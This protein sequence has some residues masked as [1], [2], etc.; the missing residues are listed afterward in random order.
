MNEKIFR[1]WAKLVFALA[2]LSVLA[3]LAG[4]STEVDKVRHNFWMNW[5]KALSTAHRM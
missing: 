2:L 5:R 1:I 4:C 3:S